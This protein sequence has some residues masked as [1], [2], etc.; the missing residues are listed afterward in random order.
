[1]CIMCIIQNVKFRQIE[2][3]GIRF[4]TQML[5]T[6]CYFLKYFQLTF[7]FQIHFNICFIDML[8]HKFLISCWHFLDFSIGQTINKKEFG[9]APT[10]IYIIILNEPFKFNSTS[11]Q[12]KLNNEPTNADTCLAYYKLVLQKEL[13]HLNFYAISHLLQ[14]R[15][16][17]KMCL[18]NIIGP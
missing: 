17:K 7:A 4:A 12:Y 13:E 9:I 15:S 3:Q 14:I 2:T 1:M 18:P 11:T 16:S 8:V 5:S 6:S 10:K